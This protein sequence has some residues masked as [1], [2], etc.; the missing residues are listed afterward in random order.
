MFWGLLDGATIVCEDLAIPVIYTSD[1]SPNIQ[2]AKYSAASVKK[3]Y[4][5]FER[6]HHVLSFSQRMWQPCRMAPEVIS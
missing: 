5:C 2:T 6:A 4:P 1:L 3:S